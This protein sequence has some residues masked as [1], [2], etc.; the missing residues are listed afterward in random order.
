MGSLVGPKSVTAVSTVEVGEVGEHVLSLPSEGN[1]RVEEVWGYH[2]N[3]R[4]KMRR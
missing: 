2:W 1:A 3:E 4:G